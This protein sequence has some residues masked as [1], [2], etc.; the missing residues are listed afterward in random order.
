MELLVETTHKYLLLWED[1]EE[2][3]PDYER[4][5]EHLFGLLEL[6]AE[7]DKMYATLQ[8]ERVKNFRIYMLYAGFLSE[9]LHENDHSQRVVKL[10]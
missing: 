5:L 3:S 7:V 8:R 2:E 4:L 10:Y 1:L 6:L 9:V